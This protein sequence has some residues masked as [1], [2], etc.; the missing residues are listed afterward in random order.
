MEKIKYIVT[1]IILLCITGLCSCT[2]YN[3]IDGGLA[4][5]DFNGNMWTYF[6]A[7]GHD[8]DSLI[9][10][11]ERGGMKEWFDGSRKENITFFGI[12]NLTVM[13]FIMDHDYE[14]EQAGKRDG[15]SEE[16]IAAAKWNGVTGIP[17][18]SCRAI[19][20]RLII[21][22]RRLM[23]DDVPRGKLVNKQNEQGHVVLEKTGGQEYKCL[24]GDVFCW[25]YQR[26]YG[27]I[28]EGGEVTLW[29]LRV[30]DVTAGDR[31]ASCNIRTHTGIVHALGYDFNFKNL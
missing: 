15:L 10:M 4:K 3:Y 13:R 25:T 31:I 23:M 18:D 6:H 8:W 1:G 16:E 22:G 17:E 2:K 24:K 7:Q 9:L 26:E 5:G 27:V 30:N 14:V 29:R 19:V 28:P 11:V 12:T 21:P 20:E